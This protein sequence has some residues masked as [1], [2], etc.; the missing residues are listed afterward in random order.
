MEPEE[1]QS[2][3]SSMDRVEMPSRANR[4]PEIRAEGLSQGSVTPESRCLSLPT[5]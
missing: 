5:V 4:V 2:K 3:S 1:G